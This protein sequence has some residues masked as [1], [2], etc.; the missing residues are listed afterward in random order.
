M[1]AAEDWLRRRGVDWLHVKTLGPS[2]P[3]EDYAKTRAFYVA[4]GFWPLEEFKALWDEK[5]PA[6]MLI[7]KLER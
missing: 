3:D 5:N 6:L 7:K 2:H 1:T 4:C